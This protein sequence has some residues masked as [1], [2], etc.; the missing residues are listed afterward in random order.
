MLSLYSPPRVNTIGPIGYFFYYKA[1]CPTLLKSRNDHIVT[2]NP[3]SALS[4][5]DREK[6]ASAP[7]RFRKS[8]NSVMAI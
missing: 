3:W 4:R 7:I 1:K 8:S 2:Q 5:S 6:A